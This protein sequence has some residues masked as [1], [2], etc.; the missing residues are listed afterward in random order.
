MT[1]ILRDELFESFTLFSLLL[2]ILVVF[3]TTISTKTSFLY[4]LIAF[5]PTI[6]TM[7]VALVLYEEAKFYKIITW[8]IPI[9]LAGAFYFTA[10][11]LY[12]LNVGFEVSLITIINLIFSLLYLG[13][14]Y[15]LLK[16][17]TIKQ[18]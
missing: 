14:G 16:L 3:A 4:V 13:V 15:L 17:I 11:Y 2:M 9:I 1:K 7:V 18:K 5:L 8:I 12:I 6:I 10:S